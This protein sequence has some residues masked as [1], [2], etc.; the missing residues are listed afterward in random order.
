MDECE[1]LAGWWLSHLSEKYDSHLGWWNSHGKIIPARDP[2]Q[3]GG[4]KGYCTISD[5]GDDDDDDDDDDDN[6]VDGED[7]EEEDDVE[8]DNDV[9]E[10]NGSQDREIH[11]VRACARSKCT[12]AFQKSQFVKI[13]MKNAGPQSQTRHFVRACAVEMHI[14]ISQEPFC[15]E[16][17]R[18]LAGHGWYHLD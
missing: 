17:H 15:V 2:K 16:I 7:E 6:E 10:E 12:W 18:E 1:E 5:D 13:Y 14:D 11:F 3:R 4:A 8:E 9:E